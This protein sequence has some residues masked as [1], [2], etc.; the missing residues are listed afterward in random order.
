M[1]E[2]IKK[3]KAPAV[4]R[5][6]L[7]QR[8]TNLPTC[9]SSA[10]PDHYAPAQLKAPAAGGK[11]LIQRPIKVAIPDI[12]RGYEAI[13]ERFLNGKLIY[14]PNKENDI[15]KIELRI[16]DLA[17]PL[18]GTFDLSRCGDA[19]N[20]LSISTGYRKGKKPE[21]AGKVEIWFSPHFLIEKNLKGSAC[22]FN[23]IVGS[24]NPFTAPVGTF[25]TGGEWDDLW[26][27]QYST[28]LNWV[29]YNGN[30]DLLAIRRDPT[31][32]KSYA[33]ESHVILSLMYEEYAEARWI[34]P[35]FV[36]FLN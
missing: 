9:S 14:K 16:A 30:N 34:Q 35:F 6:E 15:G 25:F 10:S 7:I 23:E 21:N 12:A 20:Y 33:L 13:Y 24:W 8:P 36:S 4:E 2:E 1:E 26:C 29:E 11:E 19:G 18:E 3:L 17:N 22:H 28:K 27:Y 32:L 5:E 31:T